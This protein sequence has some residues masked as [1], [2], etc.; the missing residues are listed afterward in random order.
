ME[1]LLPWKKSNRFYIPYQSWYL[2]LEHPG[3]IQS[4]ISQSASCIFNSIFQ[5]QH[6]VEEQVMI[7]HVKIKSKCSC[8]LCS[9]AAIPLGKAWQPAALV[10]ARLPQR[11]AWL[12]VPNTVTPVSLFGDRLFCIDS[13][14]VFCCKGRKMAKIPDFPKAV[15]NNKNNK[16]DQDV[17]VFYIRVCWTIKGR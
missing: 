3:S 16:S 5:P 17:L 2:N 7:P 4:L 13:T 6:R 14:E 15:N 10:Q 8:T 12:H 11:G 1:Y 9:R